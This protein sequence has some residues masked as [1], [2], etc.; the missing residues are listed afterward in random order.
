MEEQKLKPCPFCGSK[1]VYMPHIGGELVG[2][3]FCPDCG[4]YCTMERNYASEKEI[5]DR[6]NRRTAEREPMDFGTL[7]DWYISSVGDE[8]P[9][10]TEQ[11]IEELLN[12]FYVIPK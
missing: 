10:W 4:L 7:L 12:D 2:I 1:N 8:P 3:V 9:V 6:W 5:A 11:H